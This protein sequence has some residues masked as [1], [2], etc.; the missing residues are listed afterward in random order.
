NLARG[1]ATNTAYTFDLASRLTSMNHNLGGTTHDALFSFVYTTASQ[2]ASRQSTNGA[3]A[4]WTAAPRADT[5][6]AN[7]LNQYS[8]V[9]G[10]TFN[11]DNNGNLISNGSRTFGY[12]LENRLVSATGTPSM[13][14]GYDPLGRLRQTTAS[15]QTTQYLYEGDRLLAE[16][17]G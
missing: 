4:A 14:L 17:N 7:G 12:D 9:T 15:G 1:N 16:Y 8:S 2:L 5:Y 10:V 11:Y 3:L 6:V 13:T